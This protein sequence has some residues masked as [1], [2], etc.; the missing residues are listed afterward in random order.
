MSFYFIRPASWR[1]IVTALVLIATLGVVL[2]LMQYATGGQ[3]AYTMDSLTY[4]DVTLNFVAG[5]PMQSSNVAAL[6]P[7]SVP[8]LNWPPAYPALWALFASAANGKVDEVPSLLNP[9][10]LILTTLT[11]F[12]VGKMVTGRSTVAAVVAL[13]NAFTPG[14]MV[15]YGHAW[16]ETL[17]I[18]LVLLAYAA[19]WKYR[20]SRE[21]FIWLALAAVCVGVANWVRYAGVAFFPILGISVLLASGALFWRRT[22]HAAGAMLL[23]V[24]LVL[25]LWLRNWQ[26]TGNVS[27]STRGGVPRIER[28]FEDVAAIV[29]LAEHSF[30]SFSMVLRANFEIPLLVAIAVLAVKAF[31]R[32]GVQWLRPP[33]IWLPI[34]WAFGYLLFLLYARKAQANVDLDLRMVAVAGPFFLFAMLPAVEAAFADRVWNLQKIVL[35]LLL[36]LLVNTGLQQAHRTHENYASDGVPRWR[37]TFGFGYRDLRNTSAASRALVEGLANIDPSTVILTDYRAVYL[38]YLTGGK[39]Y[40]PHSNDCS[41]WMR[42]PASGVLFVGSAE[43]PAW[44]VD[45][46]K[47]P[48]RWRLQRPTGRAAPSMYAD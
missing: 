37:A 14:N 30:F 7:Q 20:L 38:R 34:V 40:S 25:P 46:L 42:I 9:M 12:W 17:F 41:D 27:G 24:A 3:V 29:D 45:C 47:A 48:S 33:E 18:P 15:V 8:L 28:G 2:G 26:L 1:G 35:V 16:S 4:R 10:L 39:F 32:H 36:G 21:Q 11:I 31:K 13:V 44:A 22:L 6:A 5:H 43:L 19:F 23:G